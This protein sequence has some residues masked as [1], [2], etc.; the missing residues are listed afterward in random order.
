ML[1]SCKFYASSSA[2]KEIKLQHLVLYASHVFKILNI[3]ASVTFQNYKTRDISHIFKILNVEMSVT[4]SQFS[5]F[6]SSTTFIHI[7]WIVRFCSK[8]LKIKTLVMFSK[9]SISR[10]QSRFQNS[11]NKDISHVFKIMNIKTSLTFS[12]LYISTYQS[13]FHNSQ[14]S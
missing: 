1:N 14:H 6:S 13:H 10:H 4:F 12:K 11:Q 2:L 5:T 9:L 3:K 8:I 7:T